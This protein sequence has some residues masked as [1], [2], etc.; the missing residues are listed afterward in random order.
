MEKKRN[1]VMVNYLN[2]KPFAQGLSSADFTPFFEVTTETPSICAQQ[3]SEGKADIALVPVGA[4]PEMTDYEVITDY[5]I[6]CDGEVRTVALFSNQPAPES[7]QLLLDNHSR[8]SFL[9]SRLILEEYMG[10]HLPS[11]AT[12]IGTLTP[13]PGDLILMIGDK[14]FAYENQYQYHI[15]LGTQWKNWTGLPFVFAVW[16]ARKGVPSEDIQRLNKAL[17]QGIEQLQDIIA[18]ESQESLDLFYYYTH[19]IRYNLDDAKKEALALFL[20]KIK[21]LSTTDPAR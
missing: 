20:S 19:N 1:V 13:Q 16:I 10:I 6:G 21:T 14:V 3:F 15:D 4:L 17:C 7:K 9:L 11:K 18:R 5:C 8:T 2:A 12:D